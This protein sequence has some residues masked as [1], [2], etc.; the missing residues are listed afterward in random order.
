[1]HFPYEI[2]GIF[3]DGIN[4]HLICLQEK[5]EILF[6]FEYG[7]ETEITEIDQKFL[8]HTNQKKIP[9][10]VVVLQKPQYCA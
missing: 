9:N 6:E 4:N 1:M 2:C 5:G 3:N 8:T 10:T 7:P